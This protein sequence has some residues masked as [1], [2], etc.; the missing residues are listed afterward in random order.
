M[1]MSG[2]GGR[3]FAGFFAV[4]FLL[5][6][7]AFAIVVIISAMT[8]NNNSN[9]TS[10]SASSSSQAQQQ[11]TSKDK[12]AGTK[13]SGFTPTATVSKLQEIDLK[14]GTG[15]TVQAGDT[16]TA[17]YTGAVAAT[18]VIFQSSKDSGQPATFPLSQVIAGWSQ[19]VPGMKVGGTRRLIIPAALAYADSPP[20]GSGI[21]KNANL[22]F[23]V[24]V[25]KI[26]KQ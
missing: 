4:L 10:S 20:Q 9:D 13:L 5:T 2:K 17:D 21:P 7:S 1:S 25:E 18:G 15:P 16:V 24:T 19:G 11:A 12:L 22:V 3:F 6:S 14:A 26:D 23:D 8:Q